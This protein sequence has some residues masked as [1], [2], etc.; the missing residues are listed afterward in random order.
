MIRTTGTALFSNVFLA[1]ICL[2]GINVAGPSL[3]TAAPKSIT[4]LQDQILIQQGE[5]TAL[6]EQLDALKATVTDLSLRRLYTR[7]G[8]FIPDSAVDLN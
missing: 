4:D 1:G 2:M 7:H 5:I 8:G 6:Q 3:A